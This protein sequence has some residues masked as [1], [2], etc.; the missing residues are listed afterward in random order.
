MKYLLTVIVIFFLSVRGFP[1]LEVRNELN[2][3]C[4]LWYRV[5]M[6]GAIS[7]HHFRGKY[8][9]RQLG[10]KIGGQSSGVELEPTII[11]WRCGSTQRERLGWAHLLV[12]FV[13]R[14]VKVSLV[15]ETF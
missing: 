2:I 3:G 9:C 8:R 12:E 10:L 14:F 6:L 1:D 4:G 5:L 7:S 11:D 13:R 15:F